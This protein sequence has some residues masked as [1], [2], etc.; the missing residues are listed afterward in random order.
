MHAIRQQI[1]AAIDIIVQVSKTPSMDPNAPP[2]THQRTI[3]EIAEMGEFDPDTG[4]IEVSPIFET[5]YVDGRPQHVIAGYIPTFFE[6]MADMGLITIDNFFS[7]DE[8]PARRA[9]HAAE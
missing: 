2:H 3:I 8:H 9:A 6:E 4:E 5:T 7:D 1:A